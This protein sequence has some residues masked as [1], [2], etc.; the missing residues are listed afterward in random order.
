MDVAVVIPSYK[1]RDHILSVLNRIGPIVTR[2]YVVDDKC[3][4][5]SGKLVAEQCRDPRVVVLF[6]EINLGVGGAMVTGY[7]RAL[8]DGADVVVKLDGDG[9]MDPEL[10]P[11]FISPIERGVTDYTKGN[12]FYAIEN[13]EGM[14]FVRIFG[15]TALS[16]V[17]KLSSGYWNVMD[18]TNGYTAI[19][20]SALSALPLAKLEK[21]YFFESDMLFRLNTVR[22]VVRDVPM[23]AIYG[24]EKSNLSIFKVIR[25]FPTK[26]LG[27]FLKRIFYSYVLRDVNVCSI[28]MAAGIPMILFGSFFGAYHWY[29]SALTNST[30]PTGTIMLAVLPV[31]VGVQL[32][33]AAVSFDVANIPQQPL[34]E[35]LRP[36]KVSETFRIP[37]QKVAND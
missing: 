9:Q 30:A 12:R 16:F 17:N 29:L 10:I 6:H 37:P 31:I 3:P 7:R 26:Y 19:H 2:I 36:G 20:S 34:Q 1:V 32:L 35:T 15:N 24:D 18:P 5:G 22:A 23:K 33:L 28:Q 14:P 4:Q 8:V 25:D 11:A 21:R 27:R 13:L